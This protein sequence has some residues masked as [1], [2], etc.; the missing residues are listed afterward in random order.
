MLF[1]ASLKFFSSR[2]LNSRTF[3]SFAMSMR[4]NIVEADG[5]AGPLIHH[6]TVRLLKSRT[7]G[8]NEKSCAF[9]PVKL[10]YWSNG[11]SENKNGAIQLQIFNWGYKVGI[12]SSV[13]LFLSY[14]IGVESTST[15]L[16]RRFCQ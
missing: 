11:L 12:N 14:S 10:K 8:R 3:S 15:N 16:H 4:Q 5:L 1:I 7:D 9:V 6:E 2:K 13:H